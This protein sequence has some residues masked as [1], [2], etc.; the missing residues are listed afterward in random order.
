MSIKRVNSFKIEGDVVAISLNG[1]VG[2]GKYT[3]VDL[4]S[5]YKYNVCGSKYNWTMQKSTHVLSWDK[6][7]KQNVYLHVLINN[8]PTAEN[9]DH[10][11]RNP[12]NNLKSNL[13]SSTVKENQH[14]Q[15]IRKDNKTGYKNV[16]LRSNGS[17]G[18]TLR[19]DGNKEFLGE[20][21]S[22]EMAAYAYDLVAPVFFGEF[23]NIN[24]IAEKELLTEDE[25]SFVE[26]K[27]YKR[28]EKILKKRDKNEVVNNGEEE[29]IINQ[30]SILLDDQR[31]QMDRN[32]SIRRGWKEESVLSV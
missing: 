3:I 13:R 32:W 16:A 28:L 10:R 5:F 26:E 15:N 25:M 23:P 29:I 21:S 11:D 7:L 9:V 12:L 17:F 22:P 8:D 18:V 1:K 6:E 31:F 4:D 14:N 27:V 20:Y 19:I 30:P 2:K 24:D